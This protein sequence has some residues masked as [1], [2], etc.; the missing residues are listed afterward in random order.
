MAGYAWPWKTHK[1][2]LSKIQKEGLYDIKIENKYE[3][4]NA[5]KYIWNTTQKD[6]INSE[7]SINEIG[8]IHTTQGYDLNYAG[9]IIGWEID[10]DPI[11]NIITVCKDMYQDSKGK[12]KVDGKILHNYIKNIYT[13]LLERG[14]YGTYIYVCNE[15]FKRLLQKILYLCSS[16]A[17]KAKTFSLIRNC[18]YESIKRPSLKNY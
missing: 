14:M 10:Y 5:H 17:P 6:W 4:N 9:V 13:T 16:S 3:V 1:M 15:S 2:T 8:C 7:N 12:E 11:N 18:I